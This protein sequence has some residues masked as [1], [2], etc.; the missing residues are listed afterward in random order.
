MVKKIYDIVPGEKKSSEPEQEHSYVP[1]GR[2]KAFSFWP[3]ILVSFAVIVGI[4]YFVFPGKAEVA[5]YPKTEEVSVD[6]NITVDSSEAVVDSSNNIVPGIIFKG[7]GKKVYTETYQA[8]GT[9]DNVA[10]A[11]GT[12]RVYNKI[13]PSK[14]L[15]LV[16]GTRFLSASGELIYRA[17][18]SFTIPAAKDDNTP[19]SVDVKVT[20]AEAGTKYNIK[21]D[22]F[23]V[24]GLSGS[25]YYLSISAETISGSPISGGQDSQ[26]RLV[27]KDDISSAKDKFQ[28]KYSDAAKQALIAT[29]PQGYEYSSDDIVPD[30]NDLTVSAK[31][32]DQADTFTVSSSISTQVLVFRKDDVNKIGEALFKN[33]TSELKTIVPGSISYTVDSKTAL[34]DG[35]IQM[36]VTFKA[37][38]Y[39]MPDDAL[40]MSSLKGKD[41]NYS[42]SV[43]ENDP[44]VEKV[45]I[46]L[47]PIWQFKIPNDSSRISIS[48]KF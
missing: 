30:F 4:L 42:I 47:S 25:E 48:T 27:S 19:G 10:K 20:A 32:G 12:I 15:S 2:K 36:S 26:V 8:T 17:N 38:T 1:R 28:N 31:Q 21:S 16:A 6:G 18:G 11:A 14:A 29:I 9:G 22:T 5:I 35:K 45:E 37:K 23:S 13:K 24:P 7:D 34:K 39:S 46:K 40:L 41:R 43:L 3:V 44:G 33:G